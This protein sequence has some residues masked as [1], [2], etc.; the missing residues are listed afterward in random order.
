M[1]RPAW[2]VSVR[3]AC[4]IRFANAYH[5]EFPSLAG[6]GVVR[7]NLSGWLGGSASQPGDPE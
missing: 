6:A 7:R 3:N 1:Y 4:A 2:L 5:N